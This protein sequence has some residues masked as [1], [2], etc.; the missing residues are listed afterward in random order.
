MVLAAFLDAQRL[1]RQTVLHHLERAAFFTKATTQVF[2]LHN[3]QTQVVGHDHG[4]R[5]GEHALQLF[6][7]LG[8][9]CAVHCGLQFWHSPPGLFPTTDLA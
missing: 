8:F 6:D 3:G 5:V 7:R 1:E 4:A 9:L 2:H